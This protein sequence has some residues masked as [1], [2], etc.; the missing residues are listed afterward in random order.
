MKKPPFRVNDAPRLAQPESGQQIGW[1]QPIRD[2][3]VRLQKEVRGIELRM[4]T[5]L[6]RGEPAAIV[7]KKTFSPEEHSFLFDYKQDGNSSVMSQYVVRDGSTYEIPISFPPPGVMLIRFLQVKLYQ[8]VFVP[9]V[10]PMQVPMQ[11]GNYFL[12][13]PLTGAFQTKKFAFPDNTVPTHLNLVYSRRSSFFWNL[14]DMKSGARYSDELVC[15]QTLLPQPLGIPITGNGSLGLTPG[16]ST[17]R[18]LEFDTPWLFERDAQLTF[19]YRPINPVI[20]PAANSGY[21]PYAF[22]DREQL[23]T[24][25]NSAV[26]VQIELHGTRYVTDQDAMREG[27][28][29]DKYFPGSER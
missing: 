26:T 28:R 22:D 25:R 27:A 2:Q 8:R 11:Y 29:V 5:Q 1:L 23:N 19:L 18:Y 20:Q 7:G 24:V 9:D 13:D 15:D 10:G 12:F 6:R 17:G 14:I 21:M 4:S 3:I 16:G